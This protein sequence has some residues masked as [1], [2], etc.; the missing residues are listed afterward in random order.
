MRKIAIL[1]SPPPPWGGP[2]PGRQPRQ[3]VHLRPGEP[4]ASDGAVAGQGRGAGLQGPEGQAQERLRRALRPRQER[5]PGRAVRGSDERRDYR[6]D[7]TP[8]NEHRERYDR[9]RRRDAAGHDPRM[10]SV[11]PDLPLVAGRLLSLAYATADEIERVHVAAGYA[12]AA[13]LARALCGASSVRRMPVF[14]QLRPAAA[15]GT[16]VSSRRPDLR[17]PRYSVTTRPAGP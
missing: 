10:G 13:S 6:P 5:Q 12:I 7:V 2:R 14:Q 17:A 9:S 15:R 11:R 1:P 4:V 3:A 16:R 8:A